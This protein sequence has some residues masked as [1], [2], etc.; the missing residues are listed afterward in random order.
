VYY[1]LK[2]FFGGLKLIFTILYKE[3]KKSAFV[4]FTFFSFSGMT[5]EKIV[6]VI[7]AYYMKLMVIT[8]W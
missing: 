7:L 6:L 1:T 5:H 2:L 8:V 4:I 3:D